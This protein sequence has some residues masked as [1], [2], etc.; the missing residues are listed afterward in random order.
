LVAI[1]W[2][3]VKAFQAWQANSPEGKLAAAEEQAQKFG[4][5]L[6]RVTEAVNASNEALEKLES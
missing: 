3:A 1:V 2:I 4:D 5:A 6:N